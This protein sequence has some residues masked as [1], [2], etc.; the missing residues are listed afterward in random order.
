[1]YNA[2]RNLQNNVSE[3]WLSLL[4]IFFDGENIEV[5]RDSLEFIPINKYISLST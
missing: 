2:Q 4:I 3:S 5:Q 1:M